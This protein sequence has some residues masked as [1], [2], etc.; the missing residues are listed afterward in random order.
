MKKFL[1]LAIILTLSLSLVWAADEVKNTNQTAA[2]GKVRTT[3]QAPESQQVNPTP[4]AKAPKPAKQ[5]E[6][7]TVINPN[8]LNEP[9]VT[10]TIQAAPRR[11]VEMPDFTTREVP[12]GQVGDL[13]KVDA[14]QTAKDAANAEWQARQAEGQ[15]VERISEAQKERE[16]AESPIIEFLQNADGTNTP[17]QNTPITA[18]YL[19]NENFE[20]TWGANNGTAPAGWAVIDSGTEGSQFWWID[21]WSK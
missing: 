10:P 21:D 12:A 6:T 16:A 11:D 8:G 13:N 2:K 14:E 17:G 3:Q 4:H 1:V 19:L 18:A 15:P 9:A 5:E 7:A 20:S